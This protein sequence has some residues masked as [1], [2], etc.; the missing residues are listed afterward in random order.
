[1]DVDFLKAVNGENH[2]ARMIVACSRKCD[3]VGDVDVLT[4]C[5]SSCLEN[6]LGVSVVVDGGEKPS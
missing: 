6:M 4:R 2:K 1:M 3:V 5:V